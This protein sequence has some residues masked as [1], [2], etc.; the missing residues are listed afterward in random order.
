MNNKIYIKKHCYHIITCYITY[1]ETKIKCLI[2]H[3][4]I[5]IL[6]RIIFPLSYNRSIG[7]IVLSKTAIPTI[8]AV[9]HLLAIQEAHLICDS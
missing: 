7:Q 1:K 9:V 6:F 2:N 3:S 8:E 5:I 4:F